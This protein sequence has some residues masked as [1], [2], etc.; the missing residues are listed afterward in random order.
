[1]FGSAPIYDLLTSCRR[2]SYTPLYK[3]EIS[4]TGKNR[5]NPCRV[6]KKI[7]SIPSENLGFPYPVCK[8]IRT[9]MLK[10]CVFPNYKNMVRIIWFWIVFTVYT[11]S[12]HETYII[13]FDHQW[14][15]VTQ[16]LTSTL[17][18]ALVG[19]VFTL[20]NVR[21]ISIFILTV[22]LLS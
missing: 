7:I 1:M 9:S 8:K 11:C 16:A 12:L 4:R 13:I 15:Y 5:G 18:L 22:W 10:A 3:T 21:T 20:Y 14:F 17:L 6:C 19:I 2:S